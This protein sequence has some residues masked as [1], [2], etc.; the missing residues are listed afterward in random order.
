VHK[1]NI[2]VIGNEGGEQRLGEPILKSFRIE[3]IH[4][5]QLVEI[6]QVISIKVL[7]FGSKLNFQ[8]SK[9]EFA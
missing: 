9:T 7:Y 6:T 3:I 2:I 4:I 5:M 1:K 8:V